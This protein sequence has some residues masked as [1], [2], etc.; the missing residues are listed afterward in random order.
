MS[1][2]ANGFDGGDVMKILNKIW[3]TMIF[4]AA[5]CGPAMLSSADTPDDLIVLCYHDIPKEVDLDNFAVDQDSFINTIEYF[6]THGFHFVSLEDVVQSN[7]GI[8][9]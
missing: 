3:I 2:S 9:P 6:R 1:R 7:Q 8:K 5:L 4:V